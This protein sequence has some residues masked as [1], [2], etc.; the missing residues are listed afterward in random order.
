MG[1]LCYTPQNVNVEQSDGNILITWTAS[2]GATS[3][4][5]SRS[6]DGVNFSSHATVSTP[7]YLD[8][9]PGVGI[10]YYYIV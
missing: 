8:S 2:L 4:L 5:V 3:Y 10:M 9:L 7:S 1:T 6:T